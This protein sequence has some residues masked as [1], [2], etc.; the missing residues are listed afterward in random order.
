M[1][2]G[3]KI[4]YNTYPYLASDKQ[5]EESKSIREISTAAVEMG[6]RAISKLNSMYQAS[7]IDVEIIPFD[8]HVAAFAGHEPEV[9]GDPSKFAP[10]CCFFVHLN[11]KVQKLTLLLLLPFD[12]SHRRFQVFNPTTIIV[13][14]KLSRSDYNMYRFDTFR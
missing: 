4:I 8:E 5:D 12:L 3:S 14:S 6:K 2:A 1:K 10:P 7:G 13:L 11:I 9:W